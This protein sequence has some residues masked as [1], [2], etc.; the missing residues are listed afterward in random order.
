[1]PHAND[2]VVLRDAT[3]GPRH[4]GVYPRR[5]V[6]LGLDGDAPT[7]KLGENSILTASKA[8]L[9]QCK[10]SFELDGD[11]GWIS[12]AKVTMD[13]FFDTPL[14]K[15]QDVRFDIL[16]DGEDGQA[17][18]ECAAESADV[19]IRSARVEAGYAR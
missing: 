16:L 3:A 1:M 8:T 13:F 17:S 10:L 2:P 14:T 11:G 15:L 19:E 6:T 12:H 7:V 9:D 5:A 4:G 18:F